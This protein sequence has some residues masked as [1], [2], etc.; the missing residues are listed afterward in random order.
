MIFVLSAQLNVILGGPC[1][2]LKVPVDIVIGT[3]PLASDQYSADDVISP[4]SYHTGYSNSHGRFCLHRG[5]RNIFK[6]L[7]IKSQIKVLSVNLLTLP[8]IPSFC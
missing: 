2:S 3:V 8:C 1:C 4:P 6:N 7:V 5:I